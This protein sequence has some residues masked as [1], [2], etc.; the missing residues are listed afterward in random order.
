MAKFKLDLLESINQLQAHPREFI[1]LFQHGSLEVELYQ[2]YLK[3]N[4]EPHTRD[5][6]YIIARGS[7]TYT[8]EGVQTSVSQGDF[9]F[10]PAHKE[11]RFDSFSDDFC[12]WVLF[13]GPTGGEKGPII[14]HQNP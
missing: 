3:D 5:E 11:H 2:P 6:V 1:T 10:A 8:L 4:Q 14:N 12:T 9:L 7:A 13:Y